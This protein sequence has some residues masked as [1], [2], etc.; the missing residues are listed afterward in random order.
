M[1]AFQFIKQDVD[2]GNFEVLKFTATQFFREY[3]P[4]FGDC[5]KSDPQYA[6]TDDDNSQEKQK[7]AQKSFTDWKHITLKALLQKNTTELKAFDPDLYKQ[8]SNLHMRS[9]STNPTPSASKLKSKASSSKKKKTNGTSSYLTTTAAST[10]KLIRTTSSPPPANRRGTLSKSIRTTPSQPPANRRGTSSTSIAKMS[11]SRPLGRNVQ[12]GSRSASTTSSKCRPLQGRRSSSSPGTSAFST[13]KS[14][15][16][17]SSKRRPSHGRSTTSPGATA[18]SKKPSR[19]SPSRSRSPS[20]SRSLVRNAQS[21]STNSKSGKKSNSNLSGGRGRSRERHNP[22]K[23]KMSSPSRSTAS[24]SKPSS[25]HSAESLEGGGSRSRS[26]FRSTS[27]SKTSKPSSRARARE[28]MSSPPPKRVVIKSPTPSRSLSSPPPKGAA[29]I[30]CSP[31]ATTRPAYA[32]SSSKKILDL[33]LQQSARRGKF[34]KEQK[35]QWNEKSASYNQSIRDLASETTDKAQAAALEA[36][37][38]ATTGLSNNM[39]QDKEVFQHLTDKQYEEMERQEELEVQL[40]LQQAEEDEEEEATEMAVEPRALDYET[41]SYKAAP[42]NEAAVPSYKT[43]APSYDADSLTMPFNE[44]TDDD[45][46]TEDHNEAVFDGDEEASKENTP[47]FLLGELI[48]CFDDLGVQVFSASCCSCHLWY[49]SSKYRF[50]ARAKKD[51][52]MC[53]RC[54]SACAAG[55]VPHNQHSRT[56]CD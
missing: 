16:T 40:L 42:S 55:K 9:K 48:K 56:E 43:A 7:K 54:V 30:P 24:T 4:I 51:N 10:A 22:T 13:A 31:S 6:G 29:K 49:V 44:H 34:W 46:H 37:K 11:S 21:A 5:L 8:A 27:T 23:T 25:R 47:Q 20:G 50:K 15:Q 18:L 19:N 45:R 33:K 36:Q 14:I 12:S 38:T 3:R 35:D 53:Q 1:K 2:D 26:R 41:P 28:S 32:R 17:T 39:E 52:G